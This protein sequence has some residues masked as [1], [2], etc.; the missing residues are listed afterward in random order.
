MINIEGAYMFCK[1]DISLIENYYEAKDDK[2]E[3]WICHHRDELRILPSGMTSRRSVE[4]LKDNGRYYNCPANELIFL[5]RSEH[6]RLH[7]TGRV[8]SEET[9]AKL[10]NS[11][12]KQWSNQR[13]TETGKN[14]INNLK[15]NHKGKC[16]KVI[17]GR[18][19]Y[20]EVV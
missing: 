4:E 18:R 1:D 7:A 12:Y 11:A 13:N 5:R 2:E 14:V 9:R 8:Y 19:K 16:W 17:N 3:L 10:S 15:C 6:A 20:Y